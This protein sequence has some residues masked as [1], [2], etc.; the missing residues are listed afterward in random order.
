VAVAGRTIRVYPRP[1]LRNEA[2]PPVSNEP[3]RSEQELKKQVLAPKPYTGRV[4]TMTRKAC[5]NWFEHTNVDNIT[6][7][8]TKVFA[9]KGHDEKVSALCL[10]GKTKEQLIDI[11]KTMEDEDFQ[12]RESAESWSKFAE[13][14]AQ[15]Q[16]WPRR[17]W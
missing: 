2:L 13:T 10:Q 8:L 7:V 15:N 16:K 14:V 12:S 17:W 9:K 6:A 1:M 11:V 3:R 5:I 4:G